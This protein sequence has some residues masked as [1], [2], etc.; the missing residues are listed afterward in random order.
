MSNAQSKAPV[1]H[2]GK[3][4]WIENPLN[5]EELAYVVERRRS[6]QEYRRRWW[7]LGPV[8]LY[9]NYTGILISTYA[10]T[11]TRNLPGFLI[12]IHAMGVGTE[13]YA[14]DLPD[15]LEVLSLLAPIVVTGILTNVYQWSQREN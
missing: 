11:G 3:W 6:A 13:F 15:L 2:R 1:Y 4:L 9:P 14:Q 12:W 8:Y 10:Y 7:N 5:G